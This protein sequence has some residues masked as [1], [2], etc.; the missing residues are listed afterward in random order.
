MSKDSEKSEKTEKSD[1]LEKEEFEE[2][3]EVKLEQDKDEKS[4]N[5]ALFIQRLF[6]YILDVILVTM[7]ASLI[8]YPFTDTKKEDQLNKQYDS[9]VEKF[10]NKEITTTEYVTESSNI[11]YS[12]TKV[13][14]VNS[15]VTLVLYILYFVVFQ[16]Y[17]HGQTIGK[18][19]M[20]IQV[21]SNTGDLTM[22][23]MI[24]RGFI[25]N[26]ILLKIISLVLFIFASRSVYFSYLGLFNMTQ[27]IIVFVSILMVM[28]RKDGL[29]VHDL[30]VHTKVIQK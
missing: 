3:I 12:L 22:N 1:K 18:K 13:R 24:F 6:A 28:F 7:V 17:Y 15:I 4:S 29:A 25:A 8:S 16:L 5:K 21:V 23:Q 26:A 10:V 20:K 27:Y 14:G 2:K 9:V 30:V 11:M 19:F